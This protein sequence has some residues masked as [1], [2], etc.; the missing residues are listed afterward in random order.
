MVFIKNYHVRESETGSFISL[1]L[2]GDI[3]L[4]QSQQTGRFY[5]TN[6]RCFISSTFDEATAKLM[7]GKKIEGSI[8]RA[9]CEPY[10][11]TIPQ[12]GEVIKLAHSYEYR[13]LEIPMATRNVLVTQ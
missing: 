7:V 3:E 10:D 2:E 9:S 12:T 11:F 1:E 13:P 5:A 6:R 8:D 4:I